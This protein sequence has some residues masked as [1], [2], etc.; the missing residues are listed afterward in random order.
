MLS[1][2]RHYKTLAGIFQNM[3]HGG[4]L[5]NTL[6][7][8]MQEPMSPHESQPDVGSSSYQEATPNSCSRS[9]PRREGRLRSP[10]PQKNPHVVPTRNENLQMENRARSLQRQRYHETVAN[11]SIARSL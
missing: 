9:S 3:M 4:T 7:R 2:C 8:F 6:R 10:P 5:P 11:E 1:V